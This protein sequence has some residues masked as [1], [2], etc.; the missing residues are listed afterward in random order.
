ME[1]HGLGAVKTWLGHRSTA[2]GICA[3]FAASALLPFLANYTP[4]ANQIAPLKKD[5]ERYS[6]QYHQL[7][8]IH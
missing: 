7:T 4:V 2:A 1:L 5:L 8:C 3:W 6:A